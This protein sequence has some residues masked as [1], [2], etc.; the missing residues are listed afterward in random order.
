[1]AETDREKSGLNA[2]KLLNELSKRQSIPET[3]DLVTAIINQF[4]G[5][6]EFAKE[7]H[8]AYCRS[9]QSP[10]ASSKMLE[11]L[12]R[13]MNNINENRKQTPLER[14]SEEELES[15]ILHLMVK[16]KVQT[17]GATEKAAGKEEVVPGRTAG[18]TDPTR[19]ATSRSNRNGTS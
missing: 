5:F 7:F 15:L 18:S 11:A 19:P 10:M 14:M 3:E 17:D 16:H 12:M 9:K 8:Q 6:T 13:L 2:R 1:M 4:G